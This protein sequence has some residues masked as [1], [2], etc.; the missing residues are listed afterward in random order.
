[1]NW[2]YILLA[3]VLAIAAIIIDWQQDRTS[4]LQAAKDHALKYIAIVV[5][6]G[7]FAGWVLQFGWLRVL[8][9]GAGV[10]FGWTFL[11]GLIKKKP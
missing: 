1:M 6:A 11:Y 10:Y 8:L 7:F 5:V 3:V 2:T 9:V 4:F